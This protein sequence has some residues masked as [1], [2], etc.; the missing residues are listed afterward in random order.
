VPL[1]DVAVGEGAVWVLSGTAA[2]V[3][4]LDPKTGKVSDRI[5]LESRTGVVAPFPVALVAG[6]GAV[7]VLGGN[8]AN[9]TK[10]D[11]RIGAVETTIPLGV[12]SNPVGITPGAGAVWLADGGDGTVARIDPVTNTLTK[13]FVGGSPAGIAVGAGRTWV[14]VQP[15]LS[16]RPTGGSPTLPAPAAA[17]LGALPSSICS[18]VYYDGRHLPRYLIAS[19]LPVQAFGGGSAQTVQ[20]S[21]AIRYLLAA[22]GF[23]A[24]GYSIGYQS[25]DDSSIAAGAWTPATCARN[26][27]AFAAATRLLG[28]IGPFN[29]GC[30]KVEIPILD[31]TA[32]GPLALI[33]PTATYVGLT[34]S[35]PGTQRGEP[36]RYYPAGVRNFVRVVAADDVQ[37]AA[38]AIVAKRLGVKSLYLLDDASSYGLGVAASVGSAAQKLGLTIAGSSHWDTNKPSTLPALAAKVK[39]SGADGVFLGGTI[40]ER[41][42]ALIQHLR[43]A[44]GSGAKIVTPDGFTPFDALLR[45]GATAEGVTVSVAEPAP[46]NLPARGGLFA[47]SFGKVVGSETEPYSLGAAQA[48][49]T[50]LG[51]VA[52]SDGTRASVNAKL[53]NTPNQNGILGSFRFDTNGDTTLGI[54]TIF[55]VEKGK[56]VVYDVVVPPRSLVTPPSVNP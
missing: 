16:G 52:A 48:A 18:P 46:G 45:V 55:R 50:L 5:R 17:A 24:G 9:V 31:R 30:A 28:V 42:S 34:H 1:D 25:C 22:Q 49:E 21:D 20:M 41:G 54:V 27:H 36:G 56:V 3:F 4:E 40:D 12:G 15:G 10:I 35:G 29:S 19:D 2:T 53:R 7:W 8:P 44:L 47:D 11:S 38:D 37:G 26:A 33:S 32:T 39:Q 13:L 43:A 23:R 14:T 6:E 51:A